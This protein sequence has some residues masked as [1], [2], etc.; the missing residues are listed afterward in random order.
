MNRPSDSLGAG[1]RLALA[2]VAACV[3]VLSAP[4]SQ[5]LS[6]AIAG[7]WPAQ[8]RTIAIAST[9]VP[10]AIALLVAIL[11]IRDRRPLRYG[12]LALG[13]GIG[14]AYIVPGAVGFGEALSL[15]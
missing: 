9:A 5:Q 15:R 6:E 10:I 4:W 2:C 8:F 3:V 14:A 13:L 12:L 7:T 11:R 1:P